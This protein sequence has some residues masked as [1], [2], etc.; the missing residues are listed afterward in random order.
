MLKKGV[1]DN[2]YEYY[3]KEQRVKLFIDYDCKKIDADIT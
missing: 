2:C 1:L 3:N